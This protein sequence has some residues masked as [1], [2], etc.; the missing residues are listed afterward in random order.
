MKEKRGQVTI[1]IILAIVIVAVG[2]L[3]YLFYPKI[4]SSFSL[5]TD[6]PSTYLR[7]CIRGDLEGVVNDVSLRGGNLNPGDYFL[8]DDE[9]IS[10]LCYTNQ[11]Y[12]PC[13][14]QYP[15]LEQHI[16]EEIKINIIENVD[17]CFD[18]LKENFENKGYEVKLKKGE[19][20]VELL[21][22][23][24]IVKFEHE[25]S[26]K[27]GENVLR[28]GGN[29]NRMIS[30]ALNNNLYELISITNS[31]LNFE[32]TDGDAEVITYMDYYRDL[33]V[34]KKKQSE[35]TTIY[36]LTD[37]NNGNKFQFASRSYVLSSW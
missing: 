18:G 9:K 13:V 10:Y 8:Y 14:M 3:V 7:N 12:R 21:P 15:L 22:K 5:N 33:K 2:V 24:V 11:N 16:S 25:L 20:I 17:S 4:Q 1:F 26:L 23:R 32:A 37:K 28:Y 29:D 36:V 35:G 6:D 34:E 19:T 27:K 30:V 31:I